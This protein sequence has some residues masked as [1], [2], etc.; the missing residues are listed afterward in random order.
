MAF[1]K[2]IDER[3]YIANRI[4]NLINSDQCP[5]KLS[6]IAILTRTND[7]LKQYEIY[8]K[9][10]G[11]KVEITGGKNIFDINSVNAMIT[12]MQFLTNPEYY[13]DKL[14]S[15]LFMQPFHIDARDYKT[16][17]EFKS[18]H[19]SLVSNIRSLLEKG[20]RREYY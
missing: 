16:L 14:L 1:D 6:E 2:T 13:S 15:Y 7:E 19:K 5:E 3:A 8:L 9:A 4:K 17:T 20:V 12:Y 11:I 18:H 10:N